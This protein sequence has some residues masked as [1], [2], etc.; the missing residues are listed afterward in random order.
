MIFRVDKTIENY[1][2]NPKKWPFIFPI[3]IERLITNQKINT[4]RGMEEPYYDTF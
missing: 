4:L 3:K 2:T 1:K